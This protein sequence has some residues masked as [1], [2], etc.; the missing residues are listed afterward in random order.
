MVS[1]YQR[2]CLTMQGY[3]T[4]T[5]E[6]KHDIDLAQRFKP[7]VC[8][9]VA[10]LALFTQSVPWAVLALRNLSIGMRHLLGEFSGAPPRVGLA[11]A[12]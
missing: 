2:Y 3:G 6:E 7:G 11:W 8:V 9:A 10:L 5:D 12:G 4:L 1:G